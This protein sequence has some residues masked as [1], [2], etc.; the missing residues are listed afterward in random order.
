MEG[1][2]DPQPN[3]MAPWICPLLPIYLLLSPSAV[4]PLPFW[5]EAGLQRG[6]VCEEIVYEL[7]VTEGGSRM[8]MHKRIHLAG[9]Q[10]EFIPFSHLVP[11]PGWYVYLL[12][13]TLLELCTWKSRAGNRCLLPFIS[14]RYF[15]TYTCSQCKEDCSCFSCCTPFAREI[16]TGQGGAYAKRSINGTIFQRV[17]RQ[18]HAP[19]F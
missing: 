8:C 11:P 4:V 18:S 13:G 2:A 15:S 9:G 7:K 10:G 1:L 19:Y 3:V 16:S 6:E 12:L 17:T 14:S 5:W